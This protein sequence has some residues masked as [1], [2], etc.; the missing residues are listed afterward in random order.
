[1]NP[2]ASELVEPLAR[3]V[4][5][6]YDDLATVAGRHGL[7]TTQARALI[8]LDRPLSM[9]ALAEH[10]VC[11]ASN[12]TG[13][14]ARMEARG[15]V[16]RTPS[17][18]DRRSRTVHATPDGQRLARRIRAEMHTVHGAL[19]GLTPTERGALLPLLHRLGELL[20]RPQG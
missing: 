14:V 8:A 16:V 18:E 17:P 15:L 19:A 12:A 7:S 13:L 9:S 1:M 10:L 6:Y 20:G 2:D 5:G 11:D 3:V 4:R